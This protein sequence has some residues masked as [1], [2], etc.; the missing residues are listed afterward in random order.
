MISEWKERGE[1]SK[2]FHHVGIVVKDL[3]AAARLYGEIIGLTPRDTGIIQDQKEG[4]RALAMLTGSTIIELIQPTKAE[5]RFAGFLREKGEGLF[6]ICYYTDD[7]DEEVRMLREKGCTVEEN[8][9]LSN[10]E[11]PFRQAWVPPESAGGV[12]I[13]L[14]D[15]AL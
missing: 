6:N 9:A 3:D 14:V 8:I 11:K 7:F 2:T 13:E 10:P 12:W 1:V 4:V 5:N 15:K